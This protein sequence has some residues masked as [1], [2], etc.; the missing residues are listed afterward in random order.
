MTKL[1]HHSWPGN[2]RELQ[3]LIERAVVTMSGPTVRF[4]ERERR[5]DRASASSR[6]LAQ[7]E[8]DHIVATLQETNWVLGGWNGAAANLGLSRTTLISKMQR[9]GISDRRRRKGREKSRVCETYAT[10]AIRSLADSRASPTLPFARAG[11]FHWASA[12]RKYR[13]LS[14]KP[15]LQKPGPK[16]PGEALCRLETIL[17]EVLSVDA[18]G[19][20]ATGA[21]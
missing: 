19:P 10:S 1:Q 9:L 13:Q 7:V 6:T 12:H 20:S 15:C 16:G 5:I 3:N 18:R 14:S 4:P 21:R 11:A 2:V 8:R 17:R